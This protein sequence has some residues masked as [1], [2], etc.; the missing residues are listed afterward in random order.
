METLR[1]QSSLVRLGDT[2]LSTGQTSLIVDPPNG[3]AP[4]VSHAAVRDYYFA[5]VEYDY[6]YNRLGSL[7]IAESQAP[8]FRLITTHIDSYKHRIRCR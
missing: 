7:P 5:H 8:C 3:R 1:I 4:F 2:V 6:I